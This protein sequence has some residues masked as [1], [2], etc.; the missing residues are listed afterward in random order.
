MLGHRLFATLA[1]HACLTGADLPIHCLSDDAEGTWEFALTPSSEDRSSCGHGHPDDAMREPL[2]QQWPRSASLKSWTVELL[3]GGSAKAARDSGTWTMISDEALQVD[4]ANWQFLAFFGFQ[5]L[6]ADGDGMHL[7][8][9]LQRRHSRCNE[10]VMGWYRDRERES[11]GCWYGRRVDGGVARSFL[12]RGLRHKGQHGR[13]QQAS[14]LRRRSTS[15]ERLPSSLDWRNMSGT[16]W[17]DEPIQQS[18]CGGCY[19][20]A[21]TQML[22]A[23]HRIAN[24]DSSL[25]AFSSAFPVYCGEYTEGCQGGYPFLAAKW[26]EDVGILP[27]SCAPWTSQGSCNVKCDPGKIAPASR[28]RAANHRYVTGGED[29]ILEELSQ[30]G[31]VAVSFKSD[32]ALLEYTG[33]LWVPPELSADDIGRDGDFLAPTHSALLVGFG[34]DPSSGPYW[35]IQN[36]WGTA[37]GEK[38][39]FRINREVARGRGMESLVVASEVVRDE[40][41]QILEAFKAKLDATHSLSFASL[42]LA[43]HSTARGHRGAP[44]CRVPA[45]GAD[46]QEIIVRLDS[47]NNFRGLSFGMSAGTET[48]VQCAGPTPPECRAGGKEA[49]VPDCTSLDGCRCDLH[50]QE[51]PFPG[52]SALADKVVLMCNSAESN[53]NVL[54]IGLGGGAV[55]SYIRDRCPPQRLTLENVEKDG[56]VAGL[57]SKF[58]GFQE[59]SRSTLEIADGLTAVLRSPPSSYDA[60]LVDCFAGRDRVPASCRSTEFVDG[61]RRML[62]E[63]GLLVQNI[64]GHS[65]A[66]TEVETDFKDTIDAYTSV[67][68]QAPYREVAFNAPQSLEYILYGLKG[69]RWSSLMPVE[70]A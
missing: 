8:V 27:E 58:F 64:W 32:P 24:S 41:P 40:R 59:D 63:D 62:K 3:P 65:S 54:M 50:N 18:M 31:P 6:P 48:A 45:A 34:E 20:I 68:G 61:V 49:D 19:A 44:L 16:N 10:T 37:W 15:K 60:V 7:P 67:F 56:R 26:S 28:L 25:E 70:V 55:S 36:A 22:S 5:P 1:L 14:K 38:G 35:I 12:Q 47:E 43:T 9:L 13:S 4:V 57:A 46:D 69:R 53:I 52:M 30:S 11:W 17:V 66:S 42:S 21:A 51:L 23:R 39:S 29:A 33:G 2:L